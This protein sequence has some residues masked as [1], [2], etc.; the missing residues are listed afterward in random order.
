M[1]WHRLLLD[2]VR[3]RNAYRYELI[4]D[5][6]QCTRDSAR[7]QSSRALVDCRT[8]HTAYVRRLEG[9]LGGS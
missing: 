4:G 3:T 8:L 2:T 7:S 9:M 6:R 5:A 1:M